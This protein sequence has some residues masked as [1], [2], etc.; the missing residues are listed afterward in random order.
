MAPY[1]ITDGAH[2]RSLIARRGS[3][4]DALRTP[5][6]GRDGE[7]IAWLTTATSAW[8]PPWW[9]AI[10]TAPGLI[11]RRLGLETASEHW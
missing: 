5:R 8:P 3:S 1:P 6:R 11:A 2:Q 9:P 4:A 10:R 7:A